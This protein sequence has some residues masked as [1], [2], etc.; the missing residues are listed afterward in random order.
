MVKKRTQA[1]IESAGR[2]LEPGETPREFCITQTIVTPFVY[3]LVGPILLAFVVKQRGVMV[4]DRN[5]YVLKLNFWK[6]KLVDEVLFK[7]PLGTAEVQ[8]TGLSI[9]LAGGPKLYAMLGQ[10]GDKKRVAEL[11]RG[12]S[13]AGDVQPASQPA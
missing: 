2:F 8:E 13:V 7:A 5:V 4:T 9:A 10:F 1:L 11:I 12:G 3:F 6:T